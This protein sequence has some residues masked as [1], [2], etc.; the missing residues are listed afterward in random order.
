LL[1]EV[2]TTLEL[3]PEAYG[4]PIGERCG[5]CTACLDACPTSAFVAPFVLDARRCV[6]YQTIERREAESLDADFGE[7][8]FGCD[9]C[10]EV[11]PYNRVA[12]SGNAAPFAPLER[13]AEVGLATLVKLDEAG[14]FR[15]TDATPVR[16][17]TRATLAASAVR[18][19]AR[20]LARDPEDTDARDALDAARHH[21]EPTVVG[22]ALRFD[23]RR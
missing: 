17:A 20:R 14:F 19:A 22:M 15:L 5:S 11:C 23:P 1:G 6:S 12:P 4:A 10:Q 16:R 2:L 18:L 13:W 8:L 9:A 7:R 3:A 21:D